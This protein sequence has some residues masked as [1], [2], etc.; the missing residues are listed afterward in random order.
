MKNIL[1]LG[2]PTAEFLH[3]LRSSHGDAN[4]QVVSGA[5]FQTSRDVFLSEIFKWVLDVKPLVVTYSSG[6]QGGTELL[7]EVFAH[8]T[9]RSPEAVQYFLFDMG[10]EVKS[11]TFTKGFLSI[12]DVMTSI[13]QTQLSEPQRLRFQI[14]GELIR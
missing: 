7:A 2:Q 12:K 6:W 10:V 13:D 8:L 4:I 1:V 9:G 5:E 3:S 14:L 11:I